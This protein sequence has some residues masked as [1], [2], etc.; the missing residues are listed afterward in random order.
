MSLVAIR[1]ALEVGLNGLPDSLLT[2]YENVPFKPPA[3][4]VP[5]QSVVMLP[6]QPENPAVGAQHRREVGVMQVSL[7]Y[8]FN[9]GTRAVMLRAELIQAR[10]RRGSTWAKD[11][12]TV[13][14]DLTPAIAPGRIQDDRFVIDVSVPYYA[15]IFTT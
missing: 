3:K 7:R 13:I 12:T 8:P 1:A 10:F 6:A 14:V 15:D 9:A 5:Y 4:D 11:G 2:A